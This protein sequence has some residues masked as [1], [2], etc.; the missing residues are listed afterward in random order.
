M[1]Q[2]LFAS[3]TAQPL[4]I[5]LC[6][7]HAWVAIL[8]LMTAG[9]L[10]SICAQAIADESA[11]RPNIIFIMADDLGY[12]DTGCY[13]QQILATPNIDR[14]S[15]EGTRFTQAY[16]GGPVCAASRAVLM[17]GLHNGH[18][19]ARDNVPH[20]HSYLSA[21]DITVADV[22]K[23]AGYRT[24]GVGKWSLGDAGTIGSATRQGF[25]RWF[26]YLNQDHAHYYFTEYLD[27]DDQRLELPGN[28]KTRQNYSHHLMTD[29]ALE[30]IRSASQ[31]D[32][33]FFLYVAWT[34]PHFSSRHE[35]KDRLAVPST[36]N[37]DDR[38]WDQKSK[39]YATMVQMLDQDVGRI[40]KL[41]DDNGL[42]DDTLIVFTSDNGGHSG[43]PDRFQT[44]GP[45]RGFKSELTEGGIRV[46]FIARWPNTVP[47]NRTSNKVIAFQDMLPTF[48][49]LA[50]ATVSGATDGLS[51]AGHLTGNGS[52]AERD[53]LY[54]DYGHCRDRYD[55]AVRW[56]NWK[57]IRLGRD[58]PIQ[59][60]DLS[61]DLAETT[62][63][64][65]RHPDVVQR[66]TNIMKSAP[67]PSDRYPV[68]QIYEGRP[69]WKRKA[70][71]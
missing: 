27:D 56:Q 8:L 53:Y 1:F 17:T 68:G 23:Q 61:N 39:K 15:V 64:A 16:A 49:E 21:K 7:R 6:I 20:Y 63:V 70:A 14:L 55:Q 19:P 52:V 10:P 57:G 11:A 65:A 37:F 71:R 38:D 66:M 43:V 26:G 22:L 69:I 36:K 24:G 44:S 42:T 9:V 28:S 48:A 62:D 45:L 13:G 31:L 32:Q 29:Q 40:V 34:L 30:F 35:D 3:L 58:Q 33:P 54:W 25:D 2:H 60:F 59:L 5:S 67:T 12:G 51:I 18:A 50:G 47:A 46:P 4:S 41:I